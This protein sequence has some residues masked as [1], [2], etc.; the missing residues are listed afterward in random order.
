M[1]NNMNVD[2]EYC[3]PFDNEERGIWMKLEHCGRY[4]Y[5]CDRIISLGAKRI[6]DAA[7]ADGYGTKMLA[8]AGLDVSGLDINQGYLEFARMQNK[9]DGAS[10]YQVDFDRD[11][12]PAHLTQQDAVVCF[13]TIE[14]VNQ[15]EVLL[16]KI[17]HAL[18]VGGMLLISFPNSVF[19]KLDENGKNK[20][21]FHRHIFQLNDILTL[22]AD[23][24][25]R[26][27]SEPMGQSLCNMSYFYQ[28]KY[29]KEGRIREKV[30]NGLF[31]YDEFAIR[32]YASFLGYPNCYQVSDT[33][34]Y[35]IEAI[36]L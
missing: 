7:C 1:I 36:K 32:N 33:Y 14:H 4:L 8:S 25:F 3:D 20:D 19:E 22:L 2:L 28:S 34:S 29:Q 18:K 9:A 31:R 5:A 26:T 23:S 13:E 17:H 16:K 21:P 10:Y 27:I 12:F 6:I 35:L 11:P 30:I 15:P 24:G